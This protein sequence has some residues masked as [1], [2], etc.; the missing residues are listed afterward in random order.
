[1]N[2]GLMWADKDHKNLNTKIHKQILLM[3]F[4]G[5]NTTCN[6]LESGSIDRDTRQLRKYRFSIQAQVSRRKRASRNGRT[7]ASNTEKR[8]VDHW[9]GGGGDHIYRYRYTYIHR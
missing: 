7:K 1:M 8:E 5:L 2:D 4:G 6:K 9:G 3:S